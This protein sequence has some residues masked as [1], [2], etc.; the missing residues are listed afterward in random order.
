MLKHATCCERITKVLVRHHN[1]MLKCDHFPSIW[2][3][4]LDIILEEVKGNE[5]NKLRTMQ[6]I[7]ADLQ[8][9]MRIFLRIRIEEKL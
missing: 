1:V 5:I 9:L 7:E 4:V 3:D 6:R 2:L 8:F